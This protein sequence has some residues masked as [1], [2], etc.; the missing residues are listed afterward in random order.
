MAR[1]L[2]VRVVQDP[3]DGFTR[4]PT[5]VQP[6]DLVVGFD[7]YGQ[8]RI[9]ARMH[10][11]AVPALSGTEHK[12][13]LEAK[14]REVAAVTARLRRMWKDEFVDV[15]PLD[16]S[17]RPAP[18]RP[19]FPYATLVD[20][21]AEPADELLTAVSQL[22]AY[23]T[24]LLFDVLLGGDSEPVKLFRGFLNEVLRA[25]EPLRVRFDSDL[26]V[27]WP[28]LCLPP[29]ATDEPGFPGV[30]RRF[31][32]HRHRIEQTGGGFYTTVS[33]GR[34]HPAPA[35]PAVSLNH[36]TFVDR[37]RRT[38]APEVASV[39]A[40]SGALTER[41]TRPQLEEAL[42]DTA[43]D[44]QLMYFWCHGQF[45]PAEPEPP[46]LVL[47]LTD[48]KPIDAYTV[49]AH[50]PPRH[51]CAPF[52]P[53]VLLNACFAGLPGNADLAYLGRALIETGARGI[54]GPQMEIPQV[55]AAEY[56]LEFLS[57]YLTGGE[58]AGTIA[59]AV[60]RHFADE[61]HNPLGFAYALHCGMD[62]RLERAEPADVTS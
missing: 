38:R 36:D 18:G 46:Y 32:G 30:F 10:G 40:R 35:V 44:E 26:F 47:K 57:R 13:L 11:A 24:Q 34:E 22:A 29:D 1:D 25:D 17:G 42:Q 5:R 37:H 49:R 19:A 52:R 6:P 61:F 7:T 62:S 4:L 20:L 48:Q 2:P 27:P 3:S 45:E 43:L 59:H 31:L 55:F 39:L 12:T 28:M 23:G 21:T 51:E 58:T 41:T 9:L 60:A 50:R 16:K 54:L 15:Q 56:A 53:F 14:P 8:G 33:D